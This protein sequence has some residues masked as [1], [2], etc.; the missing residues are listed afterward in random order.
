MTAVVGAL[1]LR[2]G[3]FAD[4]YSAGGAPACLRLYIRRRDGL[5][6]RREFPSGNEIRKPRFSLQGMRIFKMLDAQDIGHA[7]ESW[8]LSIGFLGSEVPSGRPGGDIRARL[9][10]GSARNNPLFIRLPWIGG[11]VRET[12]RRFNRACLISRPA[13]A[14]IGG[15][16]RFP[17]IGISSRITGGKAACLISGL[18]KNF[19]GGQ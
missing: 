4:K 13:L 6:A 2:A 12:A 1:R 8:F 18:R 9:I 3:P 17:W 16:Y 15:F 10:S 19:E 5:L 7:V 11:T 14:I